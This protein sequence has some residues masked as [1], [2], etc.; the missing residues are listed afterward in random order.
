MNNY[1]SILNKEQQEIILNNLNANDWWDSLT[2]N[3]QD[4]EYITWAQQLKTSDYPRHTYS[5]MRKYKNDVFDYALNNNRI[6][7]KLYISKNEN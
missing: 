2:S 7:I 1:W 4:I 5:N 3:Q 6:F